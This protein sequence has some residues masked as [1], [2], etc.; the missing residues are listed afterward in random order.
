M[1]DDNVARRQYDAHLT[2]LEAEFGAERSQLTL[3][4]DQLKDQAA[5]A[6]AD[7]AKATADAAKLSEL[8]VRPAGSQDEQTS[9]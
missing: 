3:Q 5:K 8:E 9:D 2:S 1:Q 7:A 6:T 4:L